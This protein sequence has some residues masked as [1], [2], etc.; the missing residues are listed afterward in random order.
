MQIWIDA[1]ACPKAIK[2]ILYRAANRKQIP[3]ILVSNQMLFPPTS[4]FIKTVRV[5]SG[6]DV[7]DNYITQHVQ[8]SDLVITADLP[9]A[10][11]V[12]AKEAIAL[13]PR[14]ELYTPDT[15]K[16][17]LAIRNF[18]AELRDSGLL[19]GG[20]A[21]LSSKDIQKFA[22]CLDQLLAQR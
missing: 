8:K 11:A 6:F 5:A 13:N 1:D 4:A 7:A 15:I 17:R 12:V 19:R 14:G 21:A 16:Q 2:E 22:N 18:N 9:L 10:D 3:V 20:P